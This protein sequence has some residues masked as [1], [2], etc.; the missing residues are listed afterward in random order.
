MSQREELLE[1]LKKIQLEW[2]RSAANLDEMIRVIEREM[3]DKSNSDESM[4]I[5][6]R[7]HHNYRNDYARLYGWNQLYGLEQTVWQQLLIGTKK[8]S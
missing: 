3:D 2:F 8:E 4:R 1:Q 5:F 6:I 7:A